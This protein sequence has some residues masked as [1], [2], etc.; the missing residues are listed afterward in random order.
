MSN[1][2]R[3]KPIIFTVVLLLALG[4][5][6]TSAQASVTLTGYLAVLNGDPP[7]DSNL[8]PQQFILLEDG[9][10]QTLAQL[11]VDYETA[12]SVRDQKVQV[13]GQTAGQTVQAGQSVSSAPLIQVTAVKPIAA[14]N[15]PQT[16]PLVGAAGTYPWINLLCKFSDI[17]TEPHTAADYNTLLGATYPGINHYWKQ[18]SY[19]LINIDNSTTYPTTGWITLPH[20]R[21]Y[22]IPDDNGTN[23]NRA[24]MLKDCTHAAD[25]YVNFTAYKGFNMMFN[26]DLDCCAWGGWG[27]LSLDG[28][29]RIWSRTWLPPWAQKYDYIAH[30]MGHGFGLSHSSGPLGNT[31]TDNLK[32][33]ISQW[34]VMSRS[35]GTREAW[36]ATFGSY[37]PPGTIA[38]SLNTAGWIPANRLVT[39]SPGWSKTVTLE[40]LQ[41]P[42][43][44]EPLMIKI[45]VNGSSS[46]YYTVEARFKVTGAQNY[47]QSIPTS[48]V[49][50]HDYLAGRGGWPGTNT[51]PALVVAANPTSNIPEVVVNGAGAAWVAGEMYEDA[52]NNIRIRV[53][54]Q[55]T[56]SF[57]VYVAN[58]LP[59]PPT[60]T[61]PIG[62]TVTTPTLSWNAVKYAVGY[63]IELDTTNNFTSGAVISAQTTGTSYTMPP[64]TAGRTYYWHVR[65]QT[66]SG[67]A[68]AWTT[69]ASFT[70]ASAANAGVQ[71]NIFSTITPTLSWNRIP[72]ATGYKIQVSR[73]TAFSSM[74]WETTVN[75]VNTLSTQT[76]AL[77]LGLYYWRICPRKA[78][79]TTFGTCSAAD[80]FVVNVP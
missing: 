70:L 33:Y 52:T 69:T 30:E 78:D 56:S 36:D 53:N 21:S 77:D 57:T 20:P 71:R 42:Q 9:N 67:E 28:Q 37:I 25:P 64:L 23:A 41:L 45:P 74:S 51:G 6:E 75:G 66:P 79:N 50:I 26:D 73:T 68:S 12:I 2:I 14:T 63:D 55:S 60:L 35:D 27:T 43:S 59:G 46:H 3:R 18:T 13:T 19:N 48:A 4:V 40:R 24:E 17:T 15:A 80:S 38:S 10:G 62:T 54:S 11:V 7:R 31:P 39:V 1:R 58:Q 72:W 76:S 34:D 5:V 8:P 61:A 47:D 16:P 65:S 32:I 44:T 49:I 29:T 22:Y